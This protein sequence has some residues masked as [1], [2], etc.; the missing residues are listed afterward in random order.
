MSESVKDLTVRLSFQHGDTRSQITAIKNEIK[1]MDSEFR[2]AAAGAGGL[3][4]GMNRTAAEAARLEN[5]I[6]LQ[7]QAIEKYGAALNQAKDRLQASIKRH[8]EYGQRLEEAKKKQLA[9]KKE[10]DQQKAAMEAS[11]KA[12]GDSTD[13]YKAMEARLDELNKA[14]DENAKQIKALSTGYARADQ[15]MANADK[16]IQNLTMAQNEAIEAQR[17]MEDGLSKLNKRLENHSDQLEAAAGKLKDY[18]ESA[19]KTGEAQEKIGG[20]LSKGSAAIVG[21]GV[22][23]AGAAIS[24]ESSFAGVRKTVNGTEEDLSELE[25]ELLDMGKVKSIGYADLADIAENAGQLGIATQNVARFTATMADLDATTN[26]TADS[27]SSDFAKFANITNLNQSLFENMGS[28]VVELGNN[29]ATTEQEIVSMA[30]R[31]A[32]AGTQAGMTQAKILGV[33]AG[34]SS[35]GLEAEAGGTAFSTAISRMQVAVETGSEDL[36]AY[37]DVAGMSAAEF[38]AAFREDAASAFT[39]FVQGLSS[40]SQSA[41][42]MLDEMGITEVRMRDALLRSANSGELLTR[43]IEMSNRAWQEN[44]ALAKE[45]AVRYNTTASRM[46]MLG[47]K[48]Q[49]V[50]IQFG[51]SLLPVLEDGMT[52]I[53]GIVEQFAALDEEQRKQIL[54]WGAY[55]A[56]VGPAISLLGKAN[57][58]AGKAITGVGN[59]VNALS[60]SDAP[61]KTL[62]GSVGKL[63]GPA[64]IAALAV[65]AGYAAYK[66]VDW[67][68]GAKAAREATEALNE[69]AREWREINATTVYDTGTADPLARFGLSQEAFSSSA[70]EAQSWLDDLL[71]VWTDGEVETNAQVEQFAS[72]FASASDSIREK[73]ESRENLLDGLGVMDE[74][75]RTQMQADLAQLKAWDAEIKALLEKRQ[76][77]Y[78]TEEEQARLNEVIQLRAELELSYTNGDGSGYDQIITGMEAE[79]AR[80]QASGEIDMTVYGDALNALAQGRAAYNAALDESYN[81]QYAEISA[82]EDETTR[83]AALAALNEQYNQQRLE[84]E[85]AYQKAVQEAALETVNANQTDFEGQIQQVQAI[86]AELG[87]LE[88]IDLAN[89][90]NL[91][92]GLDEGTLTSLLTLIE[93]LKA[94][95]MTNDEI[96]AETGI[97]AANLLSTIQQIRDAASE[98]EGLEGLSTIFGSALPQEIVDLMVGLDMT[99]AETDWTAFLE[100]KD[101]FETSGTVN[102]TMTPLDQAAVDAWEQANSGVELEGPAAKIGLKLGDNWQSDLKTAYDNGMLAVYGENG[103][104]LEVTPKVLE[105]L[106]TSDIV[107]GV[108]ENGVYHVQVV[109]DLGSEEGLHLSG[110]IMDEKDGAWWQKL[111]NADFSAADKV[112]AINTVLAE[113]AERVKNFNELRASGDESPA[114]VNWDLFE[115]ANNIELI[116]TT[117]NDLDDADIDAISLRISNL[118]AALSSG[119]LDEETSASAIA[120]LQNL[121]TLVSAADQYLGT[122]NNVSSGIAQGMTDYGWESDATTLAASIQTAIDNALQAHS[123]A[124]KMVPSG[125]N[126]AAGIA[127]GMTDYD[128]AGVAAETARKLTGAFAGMESQGLGIGRNFGQGLYNGL[129]SKMR[130]T[131]ALARVYANQISAA[132]RSAWQIHSPSKVAENLTEMFG[133]GLERGMADWPTVSERMLDADLLAARNDGRQTINN[134]TDNRNFS[135]SANIQ[136]ERLEVRDDQ[137]VRALAIEIVNLSKRQQRGRGMKA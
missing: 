23:A 89:L 100:G 88:N 46:Q 9:L 130:S 5:R 79:I 92:A 15:S 36:Q 75:T 43:S 113:Y 25:K 84:G 97:D 13:E 71:K 1:L 65:G 42:V 78:L 95:G 54:T 7:K 4:T 93:Q 28:S 86:A 60:A 33:A 109:A 16:S 83:T 21:A 3:S 136:V 30:M 107:L 134:A 47:N 102:I 76:G 2:A 73:I 121:L 20:T 63:L 114:M 119:T 105:Q 135:T 133:A 94:S 87:D 18:G 125:T 41:I 19:I 52:A 128:F 32:A 77:G 132:F 10:I 98:V 62:I 85:Q 124:Q 45:A 50:A 91:A 129:R 82:I 106:D 34:L 111:L 11:K 68:S 27:A 131:L 22:A 59:L 120:E 122:G 29:M 24:W 64:G 99:Q 53:D 40:G 116:K 39:A 44:T 96:F 61:L 112:K 72:A 35:L 51:N 38:A 67:A 6:S 80:L 49:R 14:F 126:A 74:S 110:E 103:L 101:P 37:A 31:I 127:K 17:E 58:A 55:A 118:M 108:D 90:K 70:A 69:T 66:F 81:A 123:P 137:D 12:T 115:E 48:T 104:P 8:Q 117:L 56:A 26:L 57:K